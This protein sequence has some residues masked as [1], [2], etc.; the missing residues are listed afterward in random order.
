MLYPE[1][2]R[3]PGG[4]TPLIYDRSYRIDAEVRL[5]E[6]DEGVL[7]SQGDVN[8]GHVLYVAEGRLPPAT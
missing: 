3:I 1:M 6:G 7:I 4:V 5:R 2:S 8:G